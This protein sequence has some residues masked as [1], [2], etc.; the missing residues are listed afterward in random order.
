MRAPAIVGVS[1][2][3]L[4]SLAPGLLPR[5]AVLQG[6][7]TGLLAAGGLVLGIA[8]A[9]WLSRIRPAVA[10][11]LTLPLLVGSLFLATAHQNRVRAS[12]SM[13][14][15][16]LAYWPTALGIAAAVLTLLVAVARLVRVAHRRLGSPRLAAAIVLAASLTY[17]VAPPATQAWLESRDRALEPGVAQPLSRIR[18]GSPDSLIRWDSMGV[19]GRRFVADTSTPSSVR[20]YVGLASAPSVAARAEL[21]A[22]ELERVGGLARSAVI[23]SVPTGSGWIDGTA[24][25]GFEERFGGDVAIV[26]IQYA[27]APS[28]VGYL[29]DPDAAAESAQALYDA[30]A[31]K[32]AALDPAVRPPLYLYGQSLGA[33]GATAVRESSASQPICGVLAVG[34]PPGAGP[35]EVVTLANA[36]DSVA[37]WSPRL[38]VEPALEGPWLPVVTFLQTSVD[39]LGALGLEPGNGHVY[40]EEQALAL[41]T[42]PLPDPRPLVENA[43][44]DE[45]LLAARGDTQY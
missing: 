27:R 12:M 31:G 35:P 28:W 8:C 18:A 21:A 30:V 7:A 9:R 33:L 40:G 29:F 32:L 2:G 14:G 42:C 1:L 36:S 23:L 45:N 3:V 4:V 43:T 26:G 5:A 25:A 44:G 13:P 22:D 20:V 34:P 39:V 16:D 6:A 41:P 24:A 37:R 11:A 10:W 17:V 38:L 19:H 15:L